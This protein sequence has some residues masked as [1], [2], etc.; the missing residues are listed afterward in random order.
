MLECKNCGEP[1]ILHETLFLKTGA[2]ICPPCYGLESQERQR[3]GYPPEELKKL[4]TGE[5]RDIEDSRDNQDFPM[6]LGEDLDDLC[7]IEDLK[8]DD[9][10]E[11][12]VFF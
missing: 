9:L 3:R 5:L 11:D 8:D 12:E 4:S 6:E 1:L 2:F 10:Q 7:L